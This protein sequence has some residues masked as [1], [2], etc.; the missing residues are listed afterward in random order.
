MRL[1]NLNNNRR[2]HKVDLRISY[3]WEWLTIL[4]YRFNVR[5]DL[6]SELFLKSLKLFSSIV[7]DFLGFLSISPF[8]ESRPFM[9]LKPFIGFKKFLNLYKF[10]LMHICNILIA[11][12][13]RV[14]NKHGQYFRRAQL[15]K[16]QHF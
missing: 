1:L 12:K 6:M 2:K 14:I 7:H 11:F 3:V 5:P 15:R 10:M 13:P 4:F 9:R 8:F 16:L